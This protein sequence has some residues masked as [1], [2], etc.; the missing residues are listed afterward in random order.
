[1]SGSKL[2][3]FLRAAFPEIITSRA[4]ADRVS[5][6]G[7][8]LVNSEAALLPNYYVEEGAIVDVDLDKH[9]ELE[10]ARA[11]VHV[12]KGIVIVHDDSRHCVLSVDRGCGPNELLKRF[13]TVFG[14]DGAPHVVSRHY[15]AWSGLVVMCKQR[16]DV[17]CFDDVC[18]SVAALV[19]GKVPTGQKLR[20]CTGLSSTVVTPVRSVPSNLAGHLTLV[21]LSHEGPLVKHQFRLHCLSA[22]AS[23]PSPTPALTNRHAHSHTNAHTNAH[24]QFSLTRISNLWQYRAHLSDA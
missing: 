9:L 22:G 14:D 23:L 13:N 17:A 6:G 2:Y 3:V 19:R 16:R 15:S 20:V 21:M 11:L 24:M 1:M 8:V 5:K 18:I 10:R 4:L 12:Y 7:C